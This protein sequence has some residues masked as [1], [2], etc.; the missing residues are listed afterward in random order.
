MLNSTQTHDVKNDRIARQNANVFSQKDLR[1]QQ[2]DE[3]RGKIAA[4]PG[5]AVKQITSRTNKPINGDTFRN[6]KEVS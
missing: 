3:K 2:A 4:I 6:V 5:I 1:Q